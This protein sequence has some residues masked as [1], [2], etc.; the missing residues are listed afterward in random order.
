MGGE[1]VGVVDGWS[2]QAVYSHRAWAVSIKRRI[3]VSEDRSG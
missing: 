2:V 1:A 3:A